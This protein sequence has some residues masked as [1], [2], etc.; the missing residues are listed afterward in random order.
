V[1]GLLGWIAA[2][3]AARTGAAAGRR[4]AG[5]LLAFAVCVAVAALTIRDTS[6]DVGSVARL[7]AGA[8]MCSRCRCGRAVEKA[9]VTSLL[10]PY[11]GGLSAVAGL[12]P[13]PA[14]A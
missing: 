1:L 10:R 9:R 8:A 12:A 4:L 7:A 13:L 14:V 5:G 3:R 2:I 11:L 6:G